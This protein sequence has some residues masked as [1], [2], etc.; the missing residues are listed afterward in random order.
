MH[1]VIN[2]V[3][4]GD[5]RIELEFDDRR[6]G[7]VDFSKYLKRGGVFKKFENMDYFRSFKVNAEIGTIA[8]NDELDVAPE[9]LYAEATG[10]ELPFWMVEKDKIRSS[11]RTKSGFVAT[12]R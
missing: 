3:Y 10:T 7:I 4:K 1:D 5:Y 6:K 11:R 9:T 8:W 12:R 2:A